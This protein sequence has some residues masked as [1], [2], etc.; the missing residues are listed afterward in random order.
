[1]TFDAVVVGGFG[2]IGVCEKAKRSLGWKPKYNL[3]Y[4]TEDTVGFS[5]Q[6]LGS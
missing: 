6:H 2:H 5:K 3:G 4:V 1:V